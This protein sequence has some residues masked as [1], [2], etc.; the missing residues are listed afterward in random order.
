MMPFCN[1]HFACFVTLNVGVMKQI[2]KLIEDMTTQARATR[3]LLILLIVQ[4]GG[5]ITLNN[6]LF[7]S[8][9]ASLRIISIELN[10]NNRGC[11]LKGYTQPLLS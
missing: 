11:V 3:E 6:C 10:L 1:K 2:Q 7:S 5:I 9:E 8:P 4:V